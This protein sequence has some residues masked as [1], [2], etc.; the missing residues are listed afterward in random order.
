MLLGGRPPAKGE[1]EV[2][3]FGPG[4][5]E[6]V[7]K[8]R[9]GRVKF[10]PEFASILHLPFDFGAGHAMV[11]LMT[12]SPT[13]DPRLPTRRICGSSSSVRDLSVSSAPSSR[14]A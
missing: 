14:A 8:S 11:D 12:L 2:S 1:V 10:V 6:C 7:L 3:V 4:Y 9:D 5:G 13:T